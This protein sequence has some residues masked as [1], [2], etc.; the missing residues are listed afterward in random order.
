MMGDRGAHTLDPV[1]FAL[2]LGAPTSVEATSLEGGGETH[3]VAA[4]ITYRF[5]ARKGKPPVKLTWYEGLQAPRPPELE[6]GRKMDEQGGAIFIGDKGKLICGVY[7]GGPRLIPEAKMK[8]YERPEKTIPRVKTTHEQDWANACKK[9]VQPGANFDYSGP[10]C[11]MVLLGN[12]AKRMGTKLDWDH[13]N[14]KV[15]NIPE[16]NKYICRPY[17]DGWSL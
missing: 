1:Y 9:G 11:E 4:V 16:A 15:T 17:R 8:A 13:E 2:E 12:V 7:G 3:P 5:P 10:L 6:D 14:L